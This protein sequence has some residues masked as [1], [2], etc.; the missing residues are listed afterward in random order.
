MATDV[1]ITYVNK[2]MDP[3]QPTIFVFAKN[4]IPNFDILVDGV[5]WKTMPNVG[6]GSSC[7]FVYPVIAT[8]Q[9]MWGGCCKT[10]ALSADIGKRYSVEQ[11]STGIVLI[12][13]GNASQSTAIELSNNI[14]ISGGVQAQLRKHNKVLVTKKVVAYG[15]K[16]TFI[17]HP[18]LYW[19]VASE[20]QEGQQ[21]SSAVLNA[22]GFFEQD[23]EGVTSAVVTL[24]GNPM[25]GYQF[26]VDNNA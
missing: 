15:Q 21:I 7:E 25:D 5:A 8:V 4:Y 13:N 26:V 16:A 14:K 12:A 6:K 20:I 19:G 23:L 24:T 3:D 11:D 9:A 17:L 1:N 18:K 22:D 2:S 10:Q